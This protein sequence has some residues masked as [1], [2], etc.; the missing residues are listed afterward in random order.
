M[1]PKKR[2][3]A[4]EAIETASR[5][6]TAKEMARRVNAICGRGAAVVRSRKGGGYSLNV[7]SS[8]LRRHS[9]RGVI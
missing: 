2:R 8:R 4:R 6:S 9:L 5:R 3:V 1:V 7:K